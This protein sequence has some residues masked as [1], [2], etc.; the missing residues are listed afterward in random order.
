MWTLVRKSDASSVHERASEGMRHL[1]TAVKRTAPLVPD[2]YNY[3]IYKDTKKKMTRD[4]E[5]EHTSHKNR[6]TRNNLR[7]QNNPRS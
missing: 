2:V 7:G 5:E 3:D 4:R 6:G 1:K